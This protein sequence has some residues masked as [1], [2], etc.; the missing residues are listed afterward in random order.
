MFR[1]THNRSEW[2]L[3]DNVIFVSHPT[4][5]NLDIHTETTLAWIVRIIVWY[6]LEAQT[7]VR[8]RKVAI[9]CCAT[10]TSMWIFPEW[11]SST[12]IEMKFRRKFNQF[13]DE[14]AQVLR[15]PSVIPIRLRATK[16]F[17]FSCV[18]APYEIHVACDDDARDRECKAKKNNPQLALS[19]TSSRFAF[20]VVHLRPTSSDT[21]DNMMM[22]QGFAN[23]RFYKQRWWS[24][25][26]QNVFYWL[27]SLEDLV[28]KIYVLLIDLTTLCDA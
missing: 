27:R 19:I 9:T 26:R 22:W 6:G 28:G 25:S 1:A 8:G 15:K 2:V 21:N 16:G 17:Y 4:I 23:I 13:V 12:N 3:I 10:V 18:D 14:F 24:W 7:A 5:L 20:D 11:I